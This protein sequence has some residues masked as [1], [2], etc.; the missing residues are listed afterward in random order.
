MTIMIACHKMILYLSASLISLNLNQKVLSKRKI[1][2]NQSNIIQRVQGFRKILKTA[3]SVRIKWSN[4][5]WEMHSSRCLRCKA[6]KIILCFKT[7]T[8]N[9]NHSIIPFIF[10]TKHMIK[11][12]ISSSSLCSKIRCKIHLI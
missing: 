11:T 1:I 5:R 4:N 10:K 9:N 3:Y 2:I 7:I 6:T 8:I 12:Y